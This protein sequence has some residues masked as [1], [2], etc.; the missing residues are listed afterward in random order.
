MKQL[1]RGRTAFLVLLDLSAKFD[2]I[3]HKHLL[4]VLENRSHLGPNV[5]NL[6]SSYL[7]NRFTRVHVGTS[8]SAPKSCPYGVPQGNILG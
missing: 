7:T 2:I 8:L 6:I 4:H 3:S 5:L 1:D